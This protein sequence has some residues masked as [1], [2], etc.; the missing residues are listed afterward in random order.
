V[1]GYHA[2][3][4]AAG[5]AR[6]FGGGKLTAPLK[7]GVL[8]DF[9]IRAA[10]AA[11]VNGVFLVTGA[12]AA[13]VA[14]RA[15]EEVSRVHAADHTEGM[16]ASLRSGVASLPADAKGVLVFLGDMPAIPASIPSRLIAAL[17]A[18]A[19]AAVPV[20]QGRRGHPVAFAR[21]LFPDLLALSGDKG[22]REVLSRLGPGLAEIETDDPGVLTDVDTPDD[23]KALG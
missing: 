23:L 3:V 4:L 6:R 17:E 11:P 13:A 12:D 2:V 10:L 18:G 5:S 19:A 22:A 14:A 7:G 15:P 9:A 20:F 1:N 21:T 16:G 8:V